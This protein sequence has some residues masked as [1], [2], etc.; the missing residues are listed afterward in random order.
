MTIRDVPR[1]KPHPDLLLKAL[2]HFD[3]PPDQALYVG[4]S[5]LDRQAARGAGVRFLGF[6]TPWPPS[7]PDPAGVEAHLWDLA[8]GPTSATLRAAE[9]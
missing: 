1:P 3:V 5:D 9:T 8:A 2:A 6:R 4:D 7:A